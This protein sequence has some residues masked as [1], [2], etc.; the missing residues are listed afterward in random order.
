MQ[1]FWIEKTA[2]K[3]FRSSARSQAESG[4]A[5][6]EAPPPFK[7]Q[8]DQKLQQQIGTAAGTASTGIA[9]IMSNQPRNL[10]S[11]PEATG[12]P[13]IRQFDFPHQTATK[14]IGIRVNR[15]QLARMGHHRHRAG[16]SG[17]RPHPMCR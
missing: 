13:H 5:G 9:F 1:G 15:P 7:R 17:K 2:G 8:A 11:F 12:S 16:V 3:P 14:Q 4:N 6:L 10:K